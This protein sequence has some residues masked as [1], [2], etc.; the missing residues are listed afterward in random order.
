MRDSPISLRSA[1]QTKCCVCFVPLKIFQNFARGTIFRNIEI[2]EYRA[3][4]TLAVPVWMSLRAPAS[5]SYVCAPFSL[6]HARATEQ[7]SKLSGWI[8]WAVTPMKLCLRAVEQCVVVAMY[9]M[10]CIVSWLIIPFLSVINIFSETDCKENLI[11]FIVIVNVT[12]RRL[13]WSSSISVHVLVPW[14]YLSL[15]LV[16][17]CPILIT[18]I[19]CIW[20]CIDY[21]QGVYFLRPP[22][23]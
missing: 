18:L 2:S 21:P 4:G 9:L 14:Y 10:F 22:V 19:I 6:L 11:V 17:R 15:I 8:Q 1:V 16:G 3:F 13:P 23:S 20:S 12:I 7:L 5:T